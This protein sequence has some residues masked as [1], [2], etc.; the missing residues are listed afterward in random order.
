MSGRV[1][2]ARAWHFGK[3]AVT[4][5]V[6]LLVALLALKVAYGELGTTDIGFDDEAVALEHGLALKMPTPD[7]AP[8]Y[9]LWYAGLALVIKNP[10]NVYYANWFVLVAVLPVLLYAL[11]RRLGAPFLP[12]VVVSTLWTIG[13]ATRTWPFVTLFATV[14]IATGAIAI[15]HAR[16]WSRAL[17]ITSV[18][19]SVSSFVRPELAGPSL[20]VA[21]AAAIAALASLRSRSKEWR[22]AL[23]E[24]ALAVGPLLVLRRLL[25]NPMEGD[26]SIFAFGQHYGLNRIEAF[27]LKIDPWTNWYPLYHDAFP[28]AQSVL[29]AMRENPAQFRW[30]VLRN[31]TLIVPEFRHFIKPLFHIPEALGV[32]FEALLF[33]VVASGLIAMLGSR[34][35]IVWDKLGKITP[36]MAVVLAATFGA[37]LIV[38][39]RQH[40]IVTATFLAFA[41]LAG[42]CNALAGPAKARWAILER[43]DGRVA[44]AVL[45]LALVLVPT[46]RPGR[47]PALLSPEGQ[48]PAQ[49]FAGRE[50]VEVLRGLNFTGPITILESSYSRGLYAGA[51]FK[52]VTQAEKAAPFWAFVHERG[53]DVIVIDDRLRADPRFR[54]D[55][56]FAAF[57]DGR[58]REDFRVIAVPEV[59]VDIAVRAKVLRD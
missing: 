56:E 37:L 30:H 52:S 20:L 17:A 44:A 18:T 25:G 8:L 31:L 45:A 42:A 29:G 43:I 39:P 11:A 28:H 34:R 22:G 51:R 26:R 59:H 1:A 49:R 54:D 58:S 47:L 38:R 57:Q 9:S 27:N 12:A 41:M 33:L 2:E 36:L 32:V 53:I 46:Y 19:M 50:A 10:A 13:Q 3:P 5:G 16:T 48:P 40:Y 35:R 23:V 6:P 7:W 15:T 24:G 21:A 55:V 4:I 14:L